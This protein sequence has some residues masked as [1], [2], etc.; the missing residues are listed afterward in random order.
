M[1]AGAVQQ[2]AAGLASLPFALAVREHPIHWSLR[3]VAA[4][5]YL[6]MFGSIV[7]YSAYIYALDR[8]P[9][10]M[11]PAEKTPRF[12]N[13]VIGRQQGVARVPL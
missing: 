8:L 6:V 13:D 1:I 3:G 5:L 12:T 7:G 10:A 9:V 2:L 11:P 4:I